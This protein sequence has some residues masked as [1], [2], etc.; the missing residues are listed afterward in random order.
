M[1]QPSIPVLALWLETGKVVSTQQKD[2]TDLTVFVSSCF[3]KMF[4]TFCGC[5]FRKVSQQRP[6]MSHFHVR[7]CMVVGFDRQGAFAWQFNRPNVMHVWRVSWLI[8]KVDAD[9]SVPSHIAPLPELYLQ[10]LVGALTGR[11]FVAK[12]VQHRFVCEQ[13]WKAWKLGQ[14]RH[15]EL[16]AWLL[17]IHVQQ[18]QSIIGTW[19]RTRLE[20]AQ[21]QIEKKKLT[22]QKDAKSA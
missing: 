8:S 3:M 6:P 17:W 1:T 10:T 13:F 16:A 20:T 5:I 18:P 9:A 14:V 2:L 22:T 11:A 15:C 7:H 12:F 21:K 19:G 4:W